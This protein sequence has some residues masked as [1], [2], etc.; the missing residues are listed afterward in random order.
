MKPYRTEAPLG[1]AL[2]VCLMILSIVTVLGTAAILTCST[3]TKIAHT[4][5]ISE[6]AFYAAEAGIEHILCISDPVSLSADTVIRSNPLVSKAASGPAYEVTVLDQIEQPW[7]VYV[8]HVESVGY[9]NRRKAR[10][11]LRCDI[12]LV[13]SAEEGGLIRD[14]G[15]YPYEYY[16][17]RPVGSEKTRAGSEE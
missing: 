14:P 9:D 4:T 15:R 5:R 2:I 3:E 7:D 17:R 13:P 1:S 12:Q 11:V 6:E 10:R 8:I 16:G